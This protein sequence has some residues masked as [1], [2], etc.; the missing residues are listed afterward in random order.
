MIYSDSDNTNRD[1]QTR[2][3][4]IDL[5]QRYKVPIRCM[6]FQGSFELAWHNNLYRAYNLPE[7]VLL[8]E[9]GDLCYFLT[10]T[11]THLFSRH[12][13]PNVN[14]SHMLHSPIIKLAMKP[15]SFPKV[16]RR[17][18]RLTGCLKAQKRS[19]NVGI[20]GFSSTESNDTRTNARYHSHCALLL[21]ITRAS[22]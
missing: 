1:K 9:V 13:S 14:S 8:R 7:S 19:V 3:H 20:C 4:Y 2:R 15:P 21:Y 6:H 10:C 18:G 17:L 22:A 11:L 16:L 5:A 12:I